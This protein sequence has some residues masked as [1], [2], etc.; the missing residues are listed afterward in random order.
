MSCF[1]VLSHIAPGNGM[2]VIL[3]GEHVLHAIHLPGGLRDVKARGLAQHHALPFAIHQQA[4]GC[5]VII[6]AGLYRQL[7]FGIR[8]T[9]AEGVGMVAALRLLECGDAVGIIDLPPLLPHKGKAAGQVAALQ[10]DA[11]RR[12]VGEDDPPLL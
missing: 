8:K 4:Q 7:T 9:Q 3:V 12:A 11:Q 2:I 10:P 5:A 1:E 6:D